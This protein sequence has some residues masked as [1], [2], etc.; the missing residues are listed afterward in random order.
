MLLGVLFTFFFHSVLLST[1][2]LFTS[3]SLSLIAGV[4]VLWDIWK[5]A[6][7]VFLWCLSACRCLQ[8][9]NLLI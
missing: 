9:Q 5:H 2:P 7:C 3:C 4:L 8:I 1:I 6:I